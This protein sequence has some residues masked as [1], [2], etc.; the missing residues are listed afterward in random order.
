MLFVWYWKTCIPTRMLHFTESK[1]WLLRIIL[2]SWFIRNVS[3]QAVLLVYFEC[4]PLKGSKPWYG[5]SQAFKLAA[6]SSFS[7]FG[8]S[9][10]SQTTN[11]IDATYIPI[12]QL[13]AEKGNSFDLLWKC[14]V[15]APSS[16]SEATIHY[17]LK[18]LI[19]LEENS[20]QTIKAIL[21]KI[22]VESE[23][24]KAK[25]TQLAQGNFR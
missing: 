7:L 15:C 5:T 6:E 23:A 21:Q 17:T 3:D 9:W 11:L 25:M 1:V 13:I 8:T 22:E 20:F 14:S 10:S 18:R 2:F 19:E 12:H 4:F 16:A 24:V